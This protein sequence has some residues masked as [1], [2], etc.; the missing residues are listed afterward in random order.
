MPIKFGD[1]NYLQYGDNVPRMGDASGIGTDFY[2]RLSPIARPIATA[3]SATVKVFDRNGKAAWAHFR[4]DS[5]REL[6]NYPDFKT[7]APMWRET[8]FSVDAVAWSSA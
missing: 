4:R 5:W 1:R 3:P 6:K 7:G 8:G 2:R